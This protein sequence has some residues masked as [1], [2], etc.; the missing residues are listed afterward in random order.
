MVMKS[1][2]E[3]MAMPILIAV[4]LGLLQGLTEF[5]PVSSSGHLLFLQTAFGL[6]NPLFLSV[7][8]H[9]AT[10]IAVMFVLRREIWEMIRHP[11][12][13]PTLYQLLER[14]DFPRFKI[15]ARV[16]IPV[17]GL[18]EWVRRQSEAVS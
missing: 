15:G 2:K 17:D 13:K 3:E 9:V 18:R 7:M 14:A 6:E 8:L 11:F 5:L 16:L 12:S 4:I 10:L 1:D